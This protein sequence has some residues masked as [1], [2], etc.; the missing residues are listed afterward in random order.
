MGLP[1]LLYSESEVK[2]A[3]TIVGLIPFFG[4][5]TG[6]AKFCSWDFFHVP[7]SSTGDRK[8]FLTRYGERDLS[9]IKAETITIN[10]ENDR[11]EP[12]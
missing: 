4:L 5:L 3:L 12:E 1:S 10:T 6:Y 9:N 7:I 11:W 8:D 2:F